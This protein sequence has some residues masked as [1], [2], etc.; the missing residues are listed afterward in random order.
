[1]TEADTAE[2]YL[3]RHAHAGDRDTWQASDDERPLTEKGQRQ[4]ERIGRALASIEFRPEAIISSPKARAAQTAELVAEA[5]GMTV[6]LDDRLA[7]GF[8]L[9]ALESLLQETD[10]SRPLLVGHD[11]DFTT[12]LSVLCDA[13]GV[14]MKKGALARIDATR[15]LHE[16]AGILRW[17]VPPDFLRGG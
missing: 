3:L 10:L 9:G 2:I 7:E 8:T 14:E 15:P 11:P 17:L 4:S 6:Q 13:P 12:L 1:V 16:G 5:L